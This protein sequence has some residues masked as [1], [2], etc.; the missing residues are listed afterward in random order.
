MINSGEMRG[1]QQVE[2]R[3]GRVIKA[4]TC[5]REL[6]DEKRVKGKEKMLYAEATREGGLV[7][8]TEIRGQQVKGDERG[9]KKM[10]FEEGKK[11]V[12]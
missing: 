6:R 3:R 9:E 8:R 4:W 12:W 10:C 2:K 1:R 11:S 5:K 7:S